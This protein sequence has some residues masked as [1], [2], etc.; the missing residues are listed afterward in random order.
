MSEDIDAI[1]LQETHLDDASHLKSRG[2]FLGDFNSHHN[3]WGYAVNN[4]DGTKLTEWTEKYSKSFRST[5]RQA[6]SNPDLCFA[7][8]NISH[9]PLA[10][11]CRVLGKI[12]HSQHK[13]SVITVGVQVPVIRSVQ[14]P[15]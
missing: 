9:R 2:K 11:S 8:K 1:C 12:P 6:S 15:R 14:L 13:P 4:T 3:M 7:T 5:R 10:S